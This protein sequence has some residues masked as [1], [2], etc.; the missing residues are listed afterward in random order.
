M[1]VDAKHFI[2]ILH[3]PIIQRAFMCVMDQSYIQTYGHSYDRT[4]CI[5]E[6]DLTHHVNVK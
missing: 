5:K 4:I 1:T 2:I 3:E 6:L